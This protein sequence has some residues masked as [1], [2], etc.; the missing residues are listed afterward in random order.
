MLLAQPVE[1]DDLIDP[2]E[3]LGLEVIPHRHQD[4]LLHRGLGLIGREDPL[5]AQ[6]RGHDH[7]RV[8]EVDG[9]SLAVGQPALV[10][11]LQQHVEDIWV[12]LLDLV[13]QQHRVGPPADGLGQL[14]SL[15]VTDVAGGR[16]DQP[17]HGVLLHVLAHVET[18]H[19]PLVVEQELGQ[20]PSELGL[21]D[22]CRAEEDER[23]D[24]AIWIA[25]S[26]PGPPDGVG[27]RAH[28]LGLTHHSA[29]QALLH[30]DEL[31]DLAFHQLDD[32]DAGPAGHDLCD[33]FLVDFLLE[34]L[35][36]AL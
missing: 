2:V 8:L 20:R 13:E 33:V 31:L 3:E 9:P 7:Y 28:G 16:A 12:S 1:H 11:D 5:G 34:E 23:A 21:S 30:L 22:P 25:Q 26:G 29:V 24:R 19:R 4:L 27:H 15:V 6:V 35:A 36:L 18:N 10:E 32:G 14:A 17:A